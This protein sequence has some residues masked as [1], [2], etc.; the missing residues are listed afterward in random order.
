MSLHG[1]ITRDHNLN[2]HGRKNFVYINLSCAVIC[3]KGLLS[4]H[5]YHVTVDSV[6]AVPFLKLFYRPDDE[7]SKD[8]WKV[9]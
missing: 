3:Y 9:G 2:F 1:I 8:L 7:G 5:L 4:Q 6:I